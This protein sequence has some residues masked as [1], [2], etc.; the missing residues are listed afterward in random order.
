MSTVYLARDTFEGK[1]VALKVANPDN[2]DNA[3]RSSLIR[4]LFFNEAKA[5]GH[6]RHPN[7]VRV[8]DAGSE[9]DIRYIAMEY[10]AGGRTVHAH[11]QR[12]TLL[13]LE[14]VVE[15][16]TKT[17]TAFDYAHRKGVIHRDIKPKNLLLTENREVKIGDF[18]VA[19]FTEMD[20]AE[21]Q[22]QGQLGSPLYMSPEQ[23]RGEQVTNQSDLFALGLVIYEMVAGQHP[24]WG[25]SVEVVS[26]KIA[27]EPYV[28]LE[29][30]R[31]DVPPMLARIVDRTL[32]K[33][34]AGRYNLGLDL[35]G[36]LSLIYDHINIPEAHLSSPK[37]FE[38]AKRLKFFSRF[39]DEEVWEVID[40]TTWQEF[41]PGAQIVQPSASINS[42]YLVVNGDAAVFR[43][44]LE[45][46]RFARGSCF[47]ELGLI[48]RPE[49]K[50]AVLALTP[51][52]V[53]KIRS[54]HLDEVS[55]QTRTNLYQAYLKATA[56]RLV[57]AT[58]SI[59]EQSGHAHQRAGRRR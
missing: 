43:D 14:D 47:G 11:C 22:V 21:T 26:R 45:V 27:R 44:G 6:L 5:A 35:A 51:V 29:E 1:D 2:P 33:H 55:S 9:G 20:L 24:F 54:S 42:L 48:D 56:E 13:P 10:V 19:V 40:G 59:V 41:E 39:S 15:M 30:V 3:K 32:K 52:T 50:G 49:R 46:E 31:P 17:A 36:D 37:Q 23:L 53:M 16:M 12:Q 25:N 57:R 7:I 38:S 58:D 18:G 4:K 28:P 8:Y 34:P